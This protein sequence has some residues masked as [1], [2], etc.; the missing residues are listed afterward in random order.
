MKENL[1]ELKK[2]MSQLAGISD[3]SEQE[4]KRTM[5]MKGDILSTLSKLAELKITE[6]SMDRSR[7]E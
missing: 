7:E 3:I 6:N 2:I 5:D 4:L 1:V